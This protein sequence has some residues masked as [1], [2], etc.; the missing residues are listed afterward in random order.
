[1][2]NSNRLREAK[3]RLEPMRGW[4]RCTNSSPIVVVLE[5]VGLQIWWSRVK[6]V[7]DTPKRDENNFLFSM[8]S[9]DKGEGREE[10]KESIVRLF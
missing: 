8:A 7:L 4:L 3:L 2:V 9:L 5:S 6:W 1:M 10:I